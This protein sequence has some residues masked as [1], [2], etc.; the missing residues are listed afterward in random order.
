MISRYLTGRTDNCIKNHWNSTIKR[1]I[2]LGILVNN[3]EKLDKDSLPE[4]LT[5]KF[6]STHETEKKN[7]V[8]ET[9]QSSEQNFITPKKT[10]AFKNVPSPPIKILR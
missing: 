6:Q 4:A 3:Q 10:S 2:K 8:F 9:P 5:S 7:F 1:K